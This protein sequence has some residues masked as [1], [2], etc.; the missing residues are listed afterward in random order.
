MR[1]KSRDATFRYKGQDRDAQE[2]GR[3]LGVSAILN[4]R[5]EQRGESMSVIA[6]LV[7]TSDGTVLWRNQYRSPVA[8][9]LFIDQEISREISE[10]LQLHLTGE[11][12]QR[13]RGP[14]TRDP[15]AYRLYLRGRY[16]LEK[17]GD[18]IAESKELFQQAVA[19]DPGYG[20]AWAG[21]AD[22]FLML[23]A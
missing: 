3:E 22:A 17:R 2:I 14:S 23:G 1:V 20:L 6:E 13:L 12:Q 11:E 4:G 19:K 15:E 21:V 8:D 5:L 7:N 16:Q 18:G 10:Q 9:A